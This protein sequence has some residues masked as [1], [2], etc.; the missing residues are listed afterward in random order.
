MYV[1]LLLYF[2]SMF[3]CLDLGFAILVPSVGL[4][5]SVFG[6][7]AYVVASVIPRVC[8]DVITC[9]IHLYGVSVLD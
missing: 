5:L 3:V 1:C 9:E 2:I 8:L 7:F 4:C 6:S